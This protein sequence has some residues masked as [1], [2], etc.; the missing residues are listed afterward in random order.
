MGRS[1]ARDH[2]EERVKKAWVQTLKRQLDSMYM[3][4][5]EKFNGF[6]LKV[7]KVTNKIRSLGTKVD[8]TTVM[9]NLLHSVPNKFQ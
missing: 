2:G 7:T 4:N 9:E 6:A 5:S 3:G 8:E 1:R